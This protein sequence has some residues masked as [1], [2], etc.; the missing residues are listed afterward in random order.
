MEGLA[1]QTA[2]VLEVYRCLFETVRQSEP[3]FLRRELLEHATAAFERSRLVGET[4]RVEALNE[5]TLS[6]AIDLLLRQGVI[7]EDR[8]A[9]V[10]SREAELARGESWDRLT[11]LSERL[12]GALSGG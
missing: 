4:S 3:R 9:P 10:H 2:G 7:E 11:E 5:T 8:Q 6:N 1:A 12:A